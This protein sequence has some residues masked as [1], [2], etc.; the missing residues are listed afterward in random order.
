MSSFKKDHPGFVAAAVKI[1]RRQQIAV[2]RPDAAIAAAN[3]PANS[4]TRK[5]GPAKNKRI[6]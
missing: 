6:K 3:R 4:F 5:H 1:A 2:G